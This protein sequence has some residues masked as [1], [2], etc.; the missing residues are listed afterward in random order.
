MPQ[1]RRSTAT[2]AVAFALATAIVAATVPAGAQHGAP[3]PRTPPRE[4]AQYDFLLGEWKLAIEVPPPSLAARIHGMPKLVGTWR[5]HRGL[6]GWGIT[7]ELRITDEAGNPVS[8]THNVRFYDPKARQ[9]AISALDVYRGVFTAPIAQWRDGEMHLTSRGT[10]AEGRA[11]VQRTRTF[12]I[13]QNGFRVQQD[14]S[15]DGGRTWEEGTLKITARRTANPPSQA[16]R[17]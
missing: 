5:A 4:V 15:L 13:S 9:W 14:R 3:P 1:R 7:D 2:T 11:Y 12:E 8:L 6:E 10:D 17:P 16:R